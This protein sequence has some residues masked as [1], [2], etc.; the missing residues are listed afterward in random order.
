MYVCNADQVSV[1]AGNVQC[2]VPCFCVSTIHKIFVLRKEQQLHKQT[3]SRGT[4]ESIL[5]SVIV[6]KW[7][8]FKKNQWGYAH[9]HTHTHQFLNGVNLSCPGGSDE[10]SP[11]LT[12]GTRKH[13]VEKAVRCALHPLITHSTM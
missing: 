7:S 11:A 6:R 13:L 2:S 9:T 5:L 4:G 10:L 1:A 3:Q 12:S 8:V